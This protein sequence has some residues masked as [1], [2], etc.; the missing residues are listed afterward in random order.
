MKYEMKWWEGK[1]DRPG[2]FK[3]AQKELKKK[4]IDFH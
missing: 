2:Y 1:R 3:A 4:R